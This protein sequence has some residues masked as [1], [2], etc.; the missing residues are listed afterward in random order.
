MGFDAFGD[1]ISFPPKDVSCCMPTVTFLSIHLDLVIHLTLH[2]Y[3]VQEMASPIMEHG[4]YLPQYNLNLNGI[5]QVPGMPSIYQSLPRS[6]LSPV[7]SPVSQQ[8]QGWPVGA[9][10]GHIPGGSIVE[11]GLFL[12]A[13]LVRTH[14][15]PTIFI[16]NRQGLNLSEDF[17]LR[18]QLT[19]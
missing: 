7:L 5:H 6:P 3:F 4:G 14:S 17:C 18:S 8:L 1:H 15:L 13:C 11:E 19:I 12:N 9:S 10:F 2:S 16:S